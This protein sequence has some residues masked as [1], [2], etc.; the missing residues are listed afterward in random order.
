MNR[1]QKETDFILYLLIRLAEVP[2][3]WAHQILTWPI[4]R[5][6]SSSWAVGKIPVLGRAFNNIGIVFP[7]MDKTERRLLLRKAIQRTVIGYYETVRM[8]RRDWINRSVDAEGLE[9]LDEA[10]AKG[11][12]VIVFSAH[13]GTFALILSYL[14]IHGYPI[15]NIGRDP[16]NPHLARYFERLREKTG[17][18]HIPKN[19]VGASV[20]QSLRWLAAGNVLSL[21]SDQ[22][23]RQGVAVPFFS[24]TVRT[25]T[26]PAVFARRLGCAVVPVSIVRR[27]RKHLLRFEPALPMSR[28]DNQDKD[29]EDNTALCNQVIERWVREDPEEWFG[30]FTRRFR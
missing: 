14:K 25:P 20:R 27:G 11:K 9:Y 8:Y 6:G 29:I 1:W 23:N 26:G 22:Y 3:R 24:Q 13:L 12:G 18:K 10:L 17:F 21:P 28:S 19:P 5:L 2:P 15:K 7:E 16:E 30:W 4:I